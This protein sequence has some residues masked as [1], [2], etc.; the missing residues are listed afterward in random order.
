MVLR[1]DVDISRVNWANQAQL[2]RRYAESVVMPKA[3]C[4]DGG[5]MPR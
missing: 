4:T 5:G 2:T 3:C 1:D